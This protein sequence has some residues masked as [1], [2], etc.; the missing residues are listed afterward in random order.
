MWS[1]PHHCGNE[2]FLVDVLFL[3]NQPD[4]DTNVKNLCGSCDDETAEKEHSRI[5][6]SGNTAGT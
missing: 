2:L 1:R 3:M 4:D 5:F 6:L